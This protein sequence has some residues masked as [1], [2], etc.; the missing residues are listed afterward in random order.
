MIGNE[1]RMMLLRKWIKVLFF[2]CWGV[3]WWY[4]DLI[5]AGFFWCAVVLTG[6]VVM[7]N[8]QD[9]YSLCPERKWRGDPNLFLLAA[10]APWWGLLNP[11]HEVG[12]W[13]WWL[14]ACVSP[15]WLLF[16]AV[17]GMWMRRWV[18]VVLP[19]LVL[20]GLPLMVWHTHQL[21]TVPY[22]ALHR[23]SGIA[24]SE[25]DSR[26]FSHYRGGSSKIYWLDLDGVELACF[27]DRQDS[28]R[29]NRAVCSEALRYAGQALDVSY[30][31]SVPGGRYRVFEIVA[32]DGVLLDYATAHQE[33]VAD[34]AAM[35]QR[36]YN[37]L[38]LM[39]LPFSLLGALA[40]W[41]VG[42]DY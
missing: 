22:S 28:S 20:L 33:Y 6:L 18:Q 30:Y 32:P 41:S 1:F 2:V 40:Y 25:L 29:V 39:T 12:G 8:W 10:T 16:W 4:R 15:L 14:W 24:P 26:S 17:V 23:V 9:A 34:E 7:L 42:E 3:A 27:P 38:L 11:M 19:A 5:G 13:R 37:G 36:F 35:W 31:Q 21:H